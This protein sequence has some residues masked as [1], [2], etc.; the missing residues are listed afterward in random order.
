MSTKR[1]LKRQLSLA[2]VVMLGTAG[3]I[4]AEIFVLTGYAAGLVGPA[5]LLA[6]L[7]G[8]LLTYSIALNYC[9][10]ATAYPV[11]G[12][13][14][15]YVREAFGDNLALFPGRARSIACPAPSMPRCRPWVLP[16]RCTFSSPSCP[17][18]LDCHCHH[19][20]FTRAEHPRSRPGG[21]CSGDAGRDP[22]ACPRRL[23]RAWA[24][25][26]PPVSIGKRSWLAVAGSST[27]GP[28][29]NL[30]KIL[31]RHFADLCGLC[32]I[33]GDRR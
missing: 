6:L 17:S 30:V 18:C 21:K 16:I 8:G 10:M 20:V 14:M 23:H 25:C 5:M 27:R 2:Q 3:T 28:R 15:T 32:R 11:T 1:R 31:Q 19:W 13:A 33:R 24:W 26:S 9:E 7:G 12:G 22:A 4:G 29:T